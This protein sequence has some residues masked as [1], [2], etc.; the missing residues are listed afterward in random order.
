MSWGWSGLVLCN[1]GSDAY[2]VEL[3]CT[4]SHTLENGLGAHLAKCVRVSELPLW[5]LLMCICAPAR[6]LLSFGQRARCDRQC[7]EDALPPRALA[8]QAFGLRRIP[9]LP[10]RQAELKHHGVAAAVCWD[11]TREA[12]RT[13][14][15]HE[16]VRIMLDDKPPKSRPNPFAAH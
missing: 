15:T 14:Y 3:I 2:Q 5:E 13:T 11:E 10:Q 1:G 8:Q 9:R 4:S 6:V 7:H 12:I 16:N